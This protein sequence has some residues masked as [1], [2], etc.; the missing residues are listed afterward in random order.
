MRAIDFPG[1][2]KD[3]GKPR[4]MTD[5]ECHSLHTYTGPLSNGMPVIISCW[6]PNKEDIE[7][8]VAGKPIWL[9]VVTGRAP[10]PV[11]LFTV[12]ENGNHNN[13]I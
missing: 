10:A 2:N 11:V 9:Q 7:A 3:W 5:E 8:I 13:G 6:Q 1:S 12:D 4:D